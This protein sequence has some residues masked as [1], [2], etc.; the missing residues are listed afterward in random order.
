M[1]ASFMCW[2][3]SFSSREGSF[4]SVNGIVLIRVRCCC[5]GDG[6]Q[7]TAVD[8]SRAT[9]VGAF[10]LSWEIIVHGGGWVGDQ[11]YPRPSV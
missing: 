4:D 11:T 7:K 6:C 1:M 2:R 10:S 3:A 5:G 9:H 8:I